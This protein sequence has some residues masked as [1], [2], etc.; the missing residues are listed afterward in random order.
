MLLVLYIFLKLS[1]TY[2]F[3]SQWWQQRKKVIWK[4]ENQITTNFKG[5]TGMQFI[6]GQ[7]WHKQ[8]ADKLKTHTRLQLVHR[9]GVVEIEP[10]ADL[11]P[12]PDEDTSLTLSQAHSP[13]TLRSSWYFVI[14]WMGLIRKSLSVNLWFISCF[15]SWNTRELH[16]ENRSQRIGVLWIGVQRQGGLVFGS[17]NQ[18]L[19]SSNQAMGRTAY[20]VAHL[21]LTT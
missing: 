11:V 6:W 2:I 14:L 12:N 17:V 8:P 18:G 7:S 20:M 16:Q 19:E 5:T 4:K 3:L 13:F 15:T 9:K 10:W 1:L 21:L